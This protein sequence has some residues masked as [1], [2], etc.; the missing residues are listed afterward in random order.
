MFMSLISLLIALLSERYLTHKL[1]QFNTYYKKYSKLVLKDEAVS[2][3]SSSIILIL[4]L[5]IPTLFC[6]IA[7]EQ[8]DN[9]LLYL[10]ASTVILI[11]CFGCSETR[12][13]YKRY[14]VAAF[15][16][17]MTTCD[18]IHTGL[19]QNKQ[20]PKMGFGQALVWLN[21]RYFI[22][23][24]LIFV[25]FGAPGALFYRL[26]TSI[27]ERCIKQ[28]EEGQKTIC[29]STNILFVIDWLPVRVIALGYMLVGHFS[30]AI[31]VWLGN[32]FD[33]NM[34][35]YEV[36]TSVAQQSEDIMIDSQD[37]TAEPCTLVRLAKR[38]L[39]LCLAFISILILTGV[40]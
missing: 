4:F 35:S 20:L 16:G 5:L 27:N 39:L 12:N 24:M 2:K 11:I 23:I 38:T 25:A 10:V 8:L 29:I 33:I 34:P 3:T 21:Y 15:R 37:C 17:D 28:D 7:L 14:L 36:L 9:S 18:L 26:L 31:S 19:L 6:Y 22:A 30:K 1:W 32:L 13:T 40:L